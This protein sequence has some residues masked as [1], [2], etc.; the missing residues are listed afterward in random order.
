MTL[1]QLL[2][3]RTVAA[4]QHFR[5]AAAELNISQ[6]SLSRSIASLEEELNIILFERQGRNVRLTKYGRIF[7]EHAE[8]IL[9]ETETALFRM[10]QLAQDEGHVDIAYVFPLANRYI[11]HTVRR[12]LSQDRY[13]NITFSFH[14][15]HTH[16]LIEGLKKELFDLVFCS[17]MENEPNIK[18]IPIIHQNMTVITPKGHPLCAKDAVSLSELSAYPLIGYDKSSGLGKYTRQI[19]SS[20]GITPNFICESPDENAISALVEE[21]FGIALVADTEAIHK[22]NIRILPLRDIHLVHTV[23]LAYLKDHYMIPA[24]RNFL[25]FIIKDGTHL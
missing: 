17:Y 8:R 2:Y 18:F 4:H 9:Q 6:P 19:F 1:N 10:H 3:F 22:R 12:F 20:H 15:L 7:L 11:P 21:D 16:Q 5:Q 24:V 25:Q 13:K 14:Q 23:Y